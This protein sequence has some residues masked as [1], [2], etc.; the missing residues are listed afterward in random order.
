VPVS[1]RSITAAD[2]VIRDTSLKPL[3]LS[4]A[5]SGYPDGKVWRVLGELIASTGVFIFVSIAL[6]AI[7][8][9]LVS[10]VWALVDAASRP[11]AAFAAANSSKALWITLIVVFWLLTGIIGLILAIVY[12]ASIRPRVRAATA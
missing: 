11:S 12:L 6:V 3:S 5:G 1:G 9:H 2:P 7:L 4:T 8:A 10:C